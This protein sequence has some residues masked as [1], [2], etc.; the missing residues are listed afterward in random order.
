MLAPSSDLLRAGI[1]LKLNQIKLAT[2][3]YLRDRTNQASGT[4]TSYA[5]AAGLLAVAGIFL[6]RRLP[7]RRHGAVSLDRNPLRAVLGVRRHRRVAARDRRNLRR[8]GRGQTKTTIAAFSL[9][10]QPPSRGDQ[11]QSAPA[12]P[13]RSR[14]GHRRV[15]PVG[16]FG[17]SGRRPSQAAIPDGTRQ[18]ADAGRPDPDGDLAGLGGNATAVASATN[19][20]LMPR[21]RSGP[22]DNLRLMAATAILVLTA[23]HFFQP[24]AKAGSSGKLIAQ[25]VSPAR[26]Q[27]REPDART[28]SIRSIGPQFP[29][30]PGNTSCGASMNAPMMTACSPPPPAWCSSDCSRYFRP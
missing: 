15:G 7:R 14:T 16:A 4:I 2:R 8:A 12:G 3:S 13:D 27:A 23:Q 1:G 20:H 6:D 25:P 18:Q 19:G 5:V 17:A 10:H 30:R 29:G 24:G 21:A 9:A 26:E 11:G 22:D 28:G